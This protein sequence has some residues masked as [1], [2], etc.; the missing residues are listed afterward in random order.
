MRGGFY[1]ENV[2]IHTELTWFDKL[3]MSGRSP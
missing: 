3:T 1:D 2:S